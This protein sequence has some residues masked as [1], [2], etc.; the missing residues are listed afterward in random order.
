MASGIEIKSL[1]LEML[2]SGFKLL[3]IIKEKSWYLLGVF[4]KEEREYL[5][6]VVPKRMYFGNLLVRK[7]VTNEYHMIEKIGRVPNGC[8][9]FEDMIYTKN[10]VL[11]IFENPNMGH[12]LK[13]VLEKGLTPERLLILFIDL[14][15]AIEELRF[16]GIFH[17]A[18][19]LD[20]LFIHN[21]R[22][23]LGGYEFCSSLDEYDEIYQVKSLHSGDLLI[24]E[25]Q[26][27]ELLPP[28]IIT[29]ASKPNTKTPY[30]S[31]AIILCFL[32]TGEF[33]NHELALS[34]KDLKKYY[35]SGML[36]VDAK[37]KNDQMDSS[38]IEKKLKFM[39]REMLK[40]SLKLRINTADI[41]HIVESLAFGKDIEYF[42]VIRSEFYLVPKQKESKVPSKV[43]SSTMA[44]IRPVQNRGQNQGNRGLSQGN[45]DKSQGKLGSLRDFSSV[46]D[47][48]MLR[49]DE[50]MTSK[51]YSEKQK[52]AK[53]P[54]GFQDPA[55]GLI[56]SMIKANKVAF[57]KIQEGQ[58]DHSNMLNDI[59]KKIENKK[60]ESGIKSHRSEKLL[61][62]LN[63]KHSIFQEEVDHLVPKITEQEERNVKTRMSINPMALQ[64]PMNPEDFKN[65]FYSAKDSRG[66]APIKGGATTMAKESEPTNIFLSP[67]ADY[68]QSSFGMFKIA[69][70][71][72]GVNNMEKDWNI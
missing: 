36:K 8:L 56:L 50:M 66:L 53:Q 44:I 23:A 2:D 59:L 31:I 57:F 70:S 7:F 26:D 14:F 58:R 62:G 71:A 72:S 67:Q 30:F 69:R 38:K 15:F 1:S 27:I 24:M 9:A 29:Y 6:K 40:I 32:L 46:E 17:R 64:M 34:L 22:L 18:I 16:K 4:S 39:I 52:K 35:L 37:F 47:S 13:V 51:Q 68:K 28:E 42:S 10:F 55:K 63:R 20:S 49:I 43:Q 12:L 3:K 60:K 25:A 19:S 21:S 5:I 54:A 41:H 33:P 61:K 48:R 11:L 65:L 45:N